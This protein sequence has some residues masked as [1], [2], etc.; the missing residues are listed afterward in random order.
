M[1]RDDADEALLRPTVSIC[2]AINTLCVR[3]GQHSTVPWPASHETYR[4][5]GLPLAHQ[6][7]F[8]NGKRYR[9]PM[10]LASSTD[11]GK[12]HEFAEQA[13]QRGDPPIIWTLKLHPVLKCNHANLVER[14]SLVQGE[15]EFLYAPYSVFEVVSVDWKAQPSWEDPHQVT[16]Q[17]APDN[18]KPADMGLPLAPWC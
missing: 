10:Y 11:L 1:L 6:A 2:R 5:G 9:A 15:Q 18:N 12:A 14:K 3:R 7:F 8:T 13:E 4:G 17:V 16:L